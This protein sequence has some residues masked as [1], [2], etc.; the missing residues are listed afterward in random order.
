MNKKIYCLA[1]GAVLGGMLVS[2]TNELNEPNN[3]P[4]QPGLLKVI[5][6]PKVVAWSGDQVLSNTFN[7]TRTYA[8][9]GADETFVYPYPFP[10][11]IDQAENI[12]IPGDAQELKDD[13][14]TSYDGSKPIYIPAGETRTFQVPLHYTGSVYVAGTYTATIGNNDPITLYILPGGSV[15]VTGV[16]TDG[17][18]IFN[19]GTLN[20][21]NGFDGVK[22][23][24]I[25][26]V[27]SDA[28]VIVGTEDSWGKTLPDG[29]A[30]YNKGGY[31][32][33]NSNDEYQNEWYYSCTLINGDII[34]DNIVKSN[35][36]IK[37]QSSGLRDICQLIST[38]LV[39]ITDGIN[40]FGMI[41]APNLKFDGAQVKLH[42][43]GL[44]DIENDITI[45]NSDCAIKPFDENSRGLIKCGSLNVVETGD[46]VLSIFPQGIYFN[47]PE[48]NIKYSPDNVGGLNNIKTRIDTELVVEPAC[49][50][51]SND[52]TE[53]PEEDGCPGTVTPG[54]YC[55]HEGSNHNPDGTCPECGE[56]GPCK[57]PQVP[58]I[59]IPDELDPGFTIDP[60]TPS[61]PQA[62]S[63]VEVNLS[64]NES[65][66][67]AVEDLVS[68]LSIHVR[69]PGDVEVFIP[70][71]QGYYCLADDFNM[72]EG[73]LY[74]DPQ[75]NTTKYVIGDP[76]IK[77]FEVT[78][79][80]TFEPGGI[81]V[82]TEGINEEVLE[83]CKKE[84]GDGVNFEVY[85]Y[86]G[87]YELKDEEWVR[88]E[89]GNI[90]RKKI[91][92]Y[93]NK[94]TVEF[95]GSSDEPN[96]VPDYYINAFKA[97]EEG[98]EGEEG[99]EGKDVYDCTVSIVDDQKT[100]FNYNGAGEHL[101]GSDRNQIYEYIYRDGFDGTTTPH[102]HDFLW[103]EYKKNHPNG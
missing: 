26:N 7:G 42:P 98:Y 90:A 2:C 67:Y 59:N 83:Y 30:I 43:E 63:E 33:F 78:L 16:S 35:G 82:T 1:L 11:E 84:Y 32:E 77:T 103:D 17:N 96:L 95:L 75:P 61:R 8:T 64:L 34:S 93:L 5:K 85:N 65:H 51:G 48:N 25:Y 60:E 69:Y 39:E 57:K 76:N 87:L 15:T 54:E 80:V 50:S 72:R 52:D 38:D 55:D 40:T 81:R 28:K 86:Y 23:K 6:D 46:P 66:G 91:L 41:T 27:G 74:L 31:V 101:N 99:S 73:D 97:N 12:T 20:L 9:R 47:V 21:P 56:D 71:P 94:A 53:L 88:A 37:F 4:N 49:G 22:I 3:V 13:W 58:G 44:I 79:T 10:V 89:N 45:T 24:N 92:E 18:N 70:V 102:D 62:G 100:D 36:K 19:A 68:K 29:V 14:N